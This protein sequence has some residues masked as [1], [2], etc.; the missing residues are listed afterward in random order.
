MPEPWDKAVVVAIFKKGDRLDPSNYR[1]ISL[2]DTC[3]KLYAR[4]LQRRIADAV[5]DSIRK[6]QYGFRKG[7]STVNALFILRRL[8][9]WVQNHKDG[10]FYM[11][12]LDWEKAFDRIDHRALII[13][14]RRMGLPQICIDNIKAIYRNPSFVV[15]TDIGTSSERSQRSGRRQGCPLSPYL[16]IITLHVIFYDLGMKLHF[17]GVL[18]RVNA[19]IAKL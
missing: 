9:E 3:Y 8:L 6:T 15:C 17:K 5:D 2:L 11:L 13:A 1:P 16:F 14:L 7:R 19:V 10:R 4:V 18:N 12:F